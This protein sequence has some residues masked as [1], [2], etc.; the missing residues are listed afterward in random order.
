MLANVT[1]RI[2]S[3]PRCKRCGARQVQQHGHEPKQTEA[4][5]RNHRKKKGGTRTGG[6]HQT[7]AR[8]RIPV[9]TVHDHPVGQPDQR[10][11]CRPFR[12]AN[13]RH[14]VAGSLKT[15][16]LAH[17]AAIARAAVVHNHADVHAATLPRS[18]PFKQAPAGDSLRA[19]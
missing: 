9:D 5:H 12:N 11:D 18:A 15:V 1:I 8:R 14:L 19:D 6:F 16:R 7:A 13:D 2:D 4:E 3:S 10:L 17:H